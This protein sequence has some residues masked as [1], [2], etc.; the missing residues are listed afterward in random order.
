MCSVLTGKGI[1][2]GVSGTAVA[3]NPINLKGLVTSMA[4]NPIDLFSLVTH[5]APTLINLY[6]FG[7]GQPGKAGS[8]A[9]PALAG[10]GRPGRAR[11]GGVLVAVFVSPDTSLYVKCLD[12]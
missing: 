3:P 8:A 5:R 12:R 9:R 11:P 7:A 4:P 1:L 6:G 2:M 10:S